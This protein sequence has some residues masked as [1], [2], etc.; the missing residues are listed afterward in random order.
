MT[1]VRLWFVCSMLVVVLVGCEHSSAKQNLP[2]QAAS[3]GDGEERR[4]FEFPAVTPS[5]GACVHVRQ[6]H[7]REYSLSETGDRALTVAKMLGKDDDP[8]IG[9][10]NQ[11]KE[12]ILEQSSVEYSVRLLEV[13]N[14]QIRRASLQVTK[15]SFG[16]SATDREPAQLPS[17]VVHLVSTDGIIFTVDDS[18]KDVVS[19]TQG[20]RH[21][22]KVADVARWLRGY[23]SYLERE[24]YSIG[25]PREIDLLQ[26]P[27]FIAET[28]KQALPDKA[29]M[30]ME[31]VSVSDD[32][33]E[34][35]ESSSLS[36]EAI[37]NFGLKGVDLVTMKHRAKSLWSWDLLSMTSTEDARMTWGTRSTGQALVVAK[38]TIRTSYRISPADHSGQGCH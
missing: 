3:R 15:H 11:F 32:S 21:V 24:T 36:G 31:L 37:Q 30:R 7:K 6:E 16:E 12:G 28:G 27:G 2:E 22:E 5:R 8:Q 23:N 25:E 9:L 13:P 20:L 18:H 14:E 35:F 33:V 17:E 29:T 1:S 34:T 10:M 19:K 4:S 26:D 38:N